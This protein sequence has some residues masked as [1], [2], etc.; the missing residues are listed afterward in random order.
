MSGGRNSFLPRES[1][2]RR[3]T[4]GVDGISPGVSA[5][6]KGGYSHDRRETLQPKLDNIVSGHSVIPAGSDTLYEEEFPPLSASIG[7]SCKAKRRTKIDLGAQPDRRIEETQGDISA[8]Q[9]EALPVPNVR[10]KEDESCLPTSFGKKRLPAIKR[11]EYRQTHNVYLAG[12]G[13]TD[14]A[15]EALPVLEPFDICPS[16][17]GRSSIMKASL[18]AKNIKKQ[19]GIEH[20]MEINCQ[21]LRPGMV[22][23]KSYITLSEQVQVVKMC[24]EL[25]IGPG[26]FYQPGYND[27]AKL[28]LQ[29]MCLGQDWDPQTRRYQNQRRIDGSKPPGIPHDF[30]LLVEKAIQDSHAFIEENYGVSNEE[31]KFPHMSPD[32]CIVNFYTT[33]GRL[34]LH[35]DRD[36]SKESLCK[37]LPVVSFSVGDSAE[38]LYGE[39]RDLQKAENV[40]LDSGDVLI[41]GGKSRHIFHGVLSII[42]DSAPPAL[43]E[44][45]ELRPGRLNLTFRQY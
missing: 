31:Y 37:G 35:Q 10:N 42:P 28:R 8:T 45:A 5:G 27:G 17:I 43:F 36:E 30:I 39:H 23:L 40:L 25:G 3:E 38:F 13:K 9:F 18:N 7:T 19:I 24:R 12:D 11:H 4:V 6:A 15:T 33:R 2:N 34:G 29:M 14:S 41:F 1:G 26:G 22:L 16:K 21:V 20:S 44:E 32:V